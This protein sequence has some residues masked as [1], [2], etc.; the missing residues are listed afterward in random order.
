MYKCVVVG[1]DGSGTADRAVETAAELAR[2][3]GAPLHIVTGFR[4]GAGG[5][6]AASGAP[7]VEASADGFA[8]EAADQVTENA[9]TAWGE[10]LQI[11]RHSVG[12]HPADAILDV[13]DQVGGDLIVVGSK[14]MHGARR[15]LGSVPN[16]VAHGAQCAVLIVKT[17]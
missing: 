8:R 10:G 11:S 4:A 14:G 7:F 2:Q 17:D 15:F 1:T 13:A 16:S 6:A 5:M 9:A 3:W 12:G